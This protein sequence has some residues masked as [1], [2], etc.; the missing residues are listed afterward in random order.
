MQGTVT[1]MTHDP[2]SD[3]N[4][5]GIPGF[6]WTRGCHMSNAFEPAIAR[7]KLARDFPDAGRERI[8]IEEIDDAVTIGA[9]RVTVIAGREGSGKSALA[10]QM[11][12]FTSHRGPVLFVMTEMTI[13]DTIN[14]VVASTGHHPV[15]Q[16]ELGPTDDVL[17]A[18]TTTL[19]HLVSSSDLTVVDVAGGS[20]TGCLSSVEE[21]LTATPAARM[22]V[23]DNLFGLALAS[24]HGDIGTIANELGH[25]MTRLEAIAKGFDV[26]VIAVHHTNRA[27]VARA[28]AKLEADSSDLGGSD[29]VGRFA[30]HVCILR[31]RVQRQNDF[32]NGLL[33]GDSTH[34]LFVP[35]NR[36]G[37]SPIVIGLRFIGAEM[38]FEGAAAA[39]P[40]TTPPP[41][42]D[43]DA[44]FRAARRNLPE[45]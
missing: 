12:Q 21:W 2:F 7:W 39:R 34:D 9:G 35:K 36:Y 30:A 6:G 24:T 18:A 8:G 11:A 43:R 4:N 44:L 19:R 16:L 3:D 37:E 5:N 29:H 15:N 23:I 17:N 13:D 25:V 40:H 28:H 14:R 10:L 26:S 38:R 27:S 22:V 32:P 20:T 33:P 31:R 1:M 41:P 45:W 42:S